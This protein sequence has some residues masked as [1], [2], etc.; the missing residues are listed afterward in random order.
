[1]VVFVASEW[2]PERWADGADAGEP[3][4]AWRNKLLP[5]GDYWDEEAIGQT[6]AKRRCLLWVVAPEVRFGHEHPMPTR[7]ALPWASRPQR[8][9]PDLYGSYGADEDEAYDAMLRE[10]LERDLASE[11]PDPVE[12]KKRID[13]IL[14]KGEEDESGRDE[15]TTSVPGDA[16]GDEG[17]PGG[18]GRGGRFT[19]GP[20]CLFP[21]FRGAVL[22]QN[23]VPS[24]YGHW[25]YAR[26]A[27]ISKGRYLLYPFGPSRWQDICPRDDRK[28]ARLAPMLPRRAGLFTRRKGDR[29]LVAMC[30]ATAVVIGSTPWTDQDGGRSA[31][32][33]SAFSSASSVTRAAGYRERRFP[34]DPFV[35]GNAA[36]LR[37][38]APQ[39][40]ALVKRYDAAM[41][42]LDE[43][44]A[45]AKPG[46]K[47]WS[48]RTVADLYLARFQFA[49]SAFATRSFPDLVPK[50]WDH[51]NDD[52]ILSHLPF[53]RMSDCLEAYDG[54]T[55][56]ADSES[57]YPR[58]LHRAWTPPGFADKPGRWQPGEIV[59]GQIGNV[60]KI[61]PAS[62]D[63]RARRD[64]EAVLKHFPEALKE[65][66]RDLI[67]AAREVMRDYRKT[68]WGWTVYYTE[69]Q[70]FVYDP[71]DG[72]LDVRPR[73]GDD[74]DHDV[75]F[76]PTR[77]PSTPGGPTTGK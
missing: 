74:T 4:A 70:G 33:W 11:I 40:N 20:P 23:D 77:P 18:A 59:A 28:L 12:R 55:L 43:A 10:D 21:R 65:R 56:E 76:S 8:P 48:H 3:H 7:P 17:V 57:H 52:Y 36:A 1:M 63:Y 71:V 2:T 29:A 25:P 5:V 32:G 16:T 31:G 9:P 68:P 49:V 73:T 24:G 35:I 53:I 27:L 67:G 6:L 58:A 51:V 50:G 69:V 14:G 75:P 44:I 46:T 15:E 64:V 72:G 30:R 54:R 41:A 60:L 26:S 61:S 62:P 39:L 47:G 38:Q 13:E 22:F 45:A 37:A 19:S 34:T 42:I 66:A